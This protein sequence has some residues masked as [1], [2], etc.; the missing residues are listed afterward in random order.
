MRKR[1]TVLLI[2]VLIFMSLTGCSGEKVY[3]KEDTTISV[4]A[5]KTFII[6]LDENPTTGYKWN[7]VIGDEAIVALDKDDYSADD[8]SGQLVGSGG[9]RILTFK[10]LSEGNSEIS[11]VYEPTYQKNVSQDML[12]YK[13]EVK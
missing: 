11:F 10:G 4:D 6:K 1:I 5:G 9:K 12:I 2:A 3:G 8:K 7:Y 13:V